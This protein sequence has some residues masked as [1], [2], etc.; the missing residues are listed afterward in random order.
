MRDGFQPQT[1]VVRHNGERGV[2]ISALKSG[3]ASTLDIVSNLKALLPKAALLLPSDV[4]IATLFDQ[5]IF[6][7][8]AVKGVVVEAIVAAG[9][10][11]LMVLLFLGQLAQHGDHRA[12]DSAVD[13]GVDPGAPGAR[14]NAQHHDAGRPRTVRGHPRGPGDRPPSRTSSGTCTTACRCTR[15]SS[16]ARSKS[17]CRPSS[18]RSASASCSCRCSSSPA[19][20]ASCSCRWPRRWCSRMILSYILSR[21]SYLRS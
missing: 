7:K 17:A 8:A 2:L 19:S 21:R 1:N 5:S 16:W 20:R 14:R 3:G 10:T 4:K 11:A 18:R 12:H 9:L 13:P 6:V 15:R